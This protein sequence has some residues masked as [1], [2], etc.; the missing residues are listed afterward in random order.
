MKTNQAGIAL[1]RQ[2]EGCKLKAY[3]DIAGILTIGVGHTGPDV[4]SNLY[5]TPLKTEQLLAHDLERFEHGVEAALKGVEANENQ[6]SAMVCLAYNIGLGAFEK[7]HLLSKFQTGD[8]EGAAEEFLRWN[9][10]QGIVVEGLTRRRTA[11]RE[12]F[13]A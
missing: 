1:I 2:F 11:E 8:T 7:S 6:F 9:H 12:L 3:R 5:I 13:L 10:A 4:L